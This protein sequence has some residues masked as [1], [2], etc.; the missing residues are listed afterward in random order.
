MTQGA[1]LVAGSNGERTS[2]PI[3]G[4]LLMSRVLNSPPPPPPP[5]VPELGADVEGPVTNRKLVELHQT[6][7]QCASCHRRMDPLGFGLEAFDAVGSFRE[8]TDTLGRLP[9][10]RTFEGA[11]GLKQVLL[12]RYWAP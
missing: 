9:D 8:G 12:E 4:M 10:G 6:R 1:F 3:R 11:D 5:N 7:A 2:P